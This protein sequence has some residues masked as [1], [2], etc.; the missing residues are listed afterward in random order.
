MNFFKT[1]TN[2]INLRCTSI[3]SGPIEI[4]TSDTAALVVR[5][6]PNDATLLNC[7]TK[8]GLVSI[9]GDLNVVG[10]ATF[11]STN[12]FSVSDN[13]IQMGVGNPS[14]ALDLG[15][16]GTY[17]SSGT[18]Y[19]GL[20][21]QNTSTGDGSFK[22]FTTGTVLPNNTVSNYSLAN[23]YLSRLYGT[24][25][26]TTQNS[27]AALGGLTSIQGTTIGSSVWPYVSTLNQNLSQSSSPTFVTVT[28]ALNGNAST[29]TYATTAGSTSTFSGSSLPLITTIG[30]TSSIAQSAYDRLKTMQ[31]VSTTASPQFSTLT[32]Q[33]AAGGADGTRLTVLSG[34][35][36][37][38]AAIGLGRVGAPDNY[39][40]SCRN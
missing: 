11:T 2:E 23:L 34:G 22:L 26:T 29:A 35:V 28:A 3:N 40:Y 20:F 1:N 18:K 24:V 14:D 17:T 36:S 6:T 37:N 9:T 27:I 10:N 7:D 15:F 30:T 16:F 8:T 38:Y 19:C 33:P 12:S 39:N 31:D 25:A 32:L 5:K 4:D 21:R 13:L